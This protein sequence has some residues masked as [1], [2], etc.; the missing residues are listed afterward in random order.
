MFRWFILPKLVIITGDIYPFG[1]ELTQGEAIRFK[2]LEFIADHFD[3]QGLSP[4]GNDS[5]AIF[6]GMVRSGSPSLHDILKESSSEDDSTSSDRESSDFP[7]PRECNVVTSIIPIA[8]T[9]LPEETL[10]LQTIPT[11]P[12]LTLGIKPELEA[13]NPNPPIGTHI[14]RNLILSR[15]ST[16][17]E[18]QNPI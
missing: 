12:Q 13:E 8:T 10:T 9:S 7:I 15:V 6:V 18:T 16:S 5:G 17:I 1:V 3:N 14:A 4:E 11:V 2:D